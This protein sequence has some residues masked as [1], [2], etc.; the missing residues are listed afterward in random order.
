MPQLR[1]R[2]VMLGLL[3]VAWGVPAGALAGGFESS[4]GG[5]PSL[6]HI[7]LTPGKMHYAVGETVRAVAT[8]SNPTSGPIEVVFP[9]GCQ[10]W[11]RVLDGAGRVW[12]DGPR[13][14]ACTAA[15]TTHTFLPGEIL[16]RNSSWDQRDDDGNQATLGPYV[17]RFQ[18][19]AADPWLMD[20]AIIEIGGAPPEASEG[21]TGTGGEQPLT[22][23]PISTSHDSPPTGSPLPLAT[24]LVALGLLQTAPLLVHR[25]WRSSAAGRFERSGG[26]SLGGEGP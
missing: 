6:L 17:L 24:A 15:L 21:P 12:Y 18:R 3:V 10:W 8:V 13:G 1:F 19:Y 14:L 16:F 2:A 22:D 11:F 4:G 26:R 7:E 23:V 20:E 5:D 25:I 9:S